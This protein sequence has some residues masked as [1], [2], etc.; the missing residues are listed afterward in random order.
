M[1]TSCFPASPMP[2]AR[3]SHSRLRMIFHGY[4]RRLRQ[5]RIHGSLKQMK[6]APCTWSAISAPIFPTTPRPNSSAASH[7]PPTSCQSASGPWRR[8]RRWACLSKAMPMCWRCRAWRARGALM[9]LRNCR[10]DHGAFCQME[11]MS[12]W[13][14]PFNPHTPRCAIFSPRRCLP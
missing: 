13:P 12:I 11:A 10:R 14:S 6:T 2:R 7:C 4:P 5:P 3:S 1:R 8:I 9:P